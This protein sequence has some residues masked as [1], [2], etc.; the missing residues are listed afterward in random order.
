MLYPATKKPPRRHGR[1]AHD[2]VAATAGIAD[3]T[4]RRHAPPGFGLATSYRKL[5][6]ALRP[7]AMGPGR[8]WPGMRA[9]LQ[10]HCAASHCAMN[11]FAA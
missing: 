2:G 5:R 1:K 10:A 9:G 8:N 3:G 11:D 6:Y 4:H 7:S